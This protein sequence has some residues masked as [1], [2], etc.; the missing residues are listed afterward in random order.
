MYFYFSHSTCSLLWLLVLMVPTGKYIN[1]FFGCYFGQLS[2]QCMS[3]LYDMAHSKILRGGPS[4]AAYTIQ[5]NIRRK[6]HHHRQGCSGGLLPLSV[7]SRWPFFFRNS[8]AGWNLLFP[9]EEWTSSL[10]TILYAHGNWTKYWI[11]SSY[12]I[13]PRLF[14]LF[15][16]CFLCL[17]EHGLPDMFYLDGNCCTFAIIYTGGRVS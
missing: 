9:V 13:F 12:T 11:Q 17:S 1:I 3:I 7:W 4:I 8:K 10:W 6:T 14:I 16:P 2:N 15:F 5:D